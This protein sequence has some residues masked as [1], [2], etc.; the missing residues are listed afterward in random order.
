M[1]AGGRKSNPMT[2]AILICG[3]TGAGKTTYSLQL[4]NPSNAIRF[5]I[6]EWMKHLFWTDAP[7]TRIYEWALERVERCE[8][9]ILALCAQMAAASQELVLDL[10]FFAQAQRQRVRHTLEG[11]GISTCIHYL[12]V[13]MEERWRRV[14]ARNSEKGETFS[15]EVSRGMFDFSEALFEVPSASELEGG[16]VVPAAR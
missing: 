5:S 4:A 12:P 11:M 7:E 16:R 1:A 14:A 15:L 2:T 6:D 9:Q 10:G 13:P 8:R 3:A